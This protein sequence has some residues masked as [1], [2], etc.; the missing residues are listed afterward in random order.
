MPQL[1][2]GAIVDDVV[3]DDVGVVPVRIA[4]CPAG[5]QATFELRDPKVPDLA[6]LHRLVA[7]SVR[8]ARRAVAAAVP[9]LLGRPGATPP[10]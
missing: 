9:F 6:V 1:D 4:R 10:L 3:V 7:P 2:G 5:W 8:E